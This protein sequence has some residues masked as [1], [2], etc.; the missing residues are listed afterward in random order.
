MPPGSRFSAAP[1]GWSGSLARRRPIAGYRCPGDRA[2]FQLQRQRWRRLG[3]RGRSIHCRP[4]VA[5]ERGPGIGY[6]I[7]PHS[8]LLFAANAIQ[9]SG[10]GEVRTEAGRSFV[11]YSDFCAYS[12]WGN[13]GALEAQD[14]TPSSAPKYQA[15]SDFAAQNPQT[16]QPDN[17]GAKAWRAKTDPCGRPPG[18]R[19]VQKAST[20]TMDSVSNWVLPPP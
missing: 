18:P 10:R 2:L 20:I 9:C 11:H 12:K 6:R 16:P 7:E 5:D 14:Q 4:G 3:I 8:K 15:L 19:Q 13:W 17:R 1:T